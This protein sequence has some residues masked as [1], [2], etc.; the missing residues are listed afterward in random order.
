VGALGHR[1]GKT[2]VPGHRELRKRAG[3]GV[4]LLGSV[5]SGDSSPLCPML[6]GCGLYHWL[7]PM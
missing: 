2:S 6:M 1:T 5:A 4:G 7:Q 3:V